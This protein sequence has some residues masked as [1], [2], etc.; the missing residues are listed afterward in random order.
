MTEVQIAILGILGTILSGTISFFQGKRWERRRQTLLI[1]AEML[2][3]IEAWLKGAER[4]IGVLG[5]TLCSIVSGSKTP[6]T[7]NFEDRRDIAMF[8]AE[9]TNIVIGI[10]QSQC[11]NTAQT[12]KLAIRLNNI[13]VSIDKRIKTDLLPLDQEILGRS[14]NGTIT[15]QF[16]H[17]VIKTKSDLEADIQEAYSLISQIKTKLT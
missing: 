1:R 6:L 10:L 4:L 5:D 3:P 8:M 12:K 16:I 2:K 14:N 13:L 11:L 15:D 7:Y 9:N 17:T